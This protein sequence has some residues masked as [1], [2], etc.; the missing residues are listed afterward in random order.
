VFI[1]EF[2]QILVVLMLYFEKE[3]LYDLMLLDFI[4]L[5]LL[6]IKEQ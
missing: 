5:F 3:K 1:L 2:E 6:A 4:I